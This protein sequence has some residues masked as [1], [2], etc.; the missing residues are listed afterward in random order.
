[1]TRYCKTMTEINGQH[2]YGIDLVSS[3]GYTVLL[4]AGAVTTDWGRICRIVRWMNR[5][6]LPPVPLEVF[7]SLEGSLRFYIF[8]SMSSHALE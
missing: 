1:M 8:C 6:N 2:W 7:Y 3:A 5:V 4:S